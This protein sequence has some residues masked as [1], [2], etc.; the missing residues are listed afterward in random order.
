MAFQ[1][2]F[3]ALLQQSLETG[4]AT[5]TTTEGGQITHAAPLYS[6][7][8]PD[9]GELTRLSIAGVIE[10]SFNQNGILVA[11]SSAGEEALGSGT[12]EQAFIF[13]LLHGPA[14]YLLLKKKAGR[15][16]KKSISAR[17]KQR[18]ESNGVKI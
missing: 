10:V 14:A 18:K 17:H 16:V 7:T 1:N 15:Q 11:P 8:V 6:C 12:P 3:V 2:S 5:A 4:K 9:E 13:I